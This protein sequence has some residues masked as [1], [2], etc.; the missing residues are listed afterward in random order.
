MKKNF[1]TVFSVLGSICL[2]TGAF[3]GCAQTSRAPGPNNGTLT[4]N[5]QTQGYGRNNLV[6]ATTQL[7]QGNMTGMNWRTGNTMN[8]T[9]GMTGSNGITGGT[10]MTG[11]NGMTGGTM[12]PRTGMTMNQTTNM[13][14]GNITG[15]MAYNQ[16][17]AEKI[18]KHLTNMNGLRNVNVMVMGNTALVGCEPTGNTTNT[19]AVRNSIIKKVKQ[20]DP[21]IVNVTVSE[22]A[23]I[24]DRMNRLGS[25]MTNNKPMK[26]ITEEFNRMING[27]TAPAK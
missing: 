1:K 3:Y 24:M 7:G 20:A 4:Q 26:T 6:N 19:T 22:S 12:N 16:Q 5:M 21:A 13:G 14:A 23:D 27:I 9:T 25:D 15:T 11:G 17:R 18:K 8:Q 10:G 2:M